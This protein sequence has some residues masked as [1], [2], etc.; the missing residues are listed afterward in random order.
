MARVEVFVPVRDH[1]P[2][3]PAFDATLRRL[4][5]L[6]RVTEVPGDE[7]PMVQTL[8][9]MLA[10]LP[11]ACDVGTTRNAKG[12]KTSWIGCKLHIDT[13]RRRETRLPTATFR[14]RAF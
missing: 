11:T 7:R 10:D 13:A 5:G 6:K 14:S 12:Y 8:S 9:E 4:C 3:R 1:E 2:G